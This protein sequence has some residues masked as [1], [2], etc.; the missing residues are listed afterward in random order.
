VLAAARAEPSPTMQATRT[1]VAVALVAAAVVSLGEIAALGGLHPRREAPVVF[2]TAAGVFAVALAATWLALGRGRSM[3]GRSRAALVGVAVAAPLAFLVWS[4]LAPALGA[5]GVHL[6]NSDGALQHGF[7][8]AFA[9]LYA[10]APFVIA[11][12]I[13]RGSDPVHPRAL[14]AALG[15]AAG[16]WGGLL[17]DVHCSSDAFVH[18]TLGHVAPIALLIAI[19]AALGARV[20]GVRGQGPRD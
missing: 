8:F 1:R 17:I 4:T 12:V 11:L 20:L 7:C 18:L 13:R 2:A 5:G 14:G 16:V 19:G 9:T 15:A 3:V 6:M 10:F